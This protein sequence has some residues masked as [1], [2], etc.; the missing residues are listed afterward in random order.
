MR[1]L[2]LIIISLNLVSIKCNEEG[3][4][5]HHKITIVNHSS[6]NIIQAMN[7]ENTSGKCILTGSII[8][9]EGIYEYTDRS[10]FEDVL[11]A[12]EKFGFYLI[13]PVHFNAPGIFYNCDSIEYKN[14]ILKHYSLT[15]EELKSTSFMITYP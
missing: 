6:E 14:T 9:P 4:H 1:K 15:L 12:S 2:L 5:C 3:A 8:L 10:C 11:S 7:I 13:D